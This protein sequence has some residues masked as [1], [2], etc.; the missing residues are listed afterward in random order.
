M[1]RKN[2]M[3]IIDDLLDYISYISDPRETYKVVYPLPT[4]LFTTFCSVLSG[5]QSWQD[6]ADYCGSKKTWFSK[7]VDLSMGIPSPWTFRRLFTLLEPE[8][9]EGLLTKVASLLLEDK[10]SDQIAIDGKS[11]RGSRRSDVSCLKYVSAWCHDNGLV[12]AEKAVAEGSHESKTIPLL[13]ETLNLKGTTVSIDAA[14]CQA[15]IAEKII[16]KKGHYVLSLKKN[17]PK[18]YEAV[19]SYMKENAQDQRAY[20][21]E[22]SFDET[23]NRLVRRRYFACPIAHLKLAV[24]WP[25]LKTAIAVET[26][27]TRSRTSKAT[28]DWRYYVSSH[29]SKN[30][31]LAQYIRNHW[32]IENRLHWVLDVQMNEDNDLKSE[33]KSAKAFATL[34]RIAL[35]IVR[36]KDQT[37]KCSV[38]R[39]MLK[40]AWNED[41]LLN[42]LT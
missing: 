28:A 19:T 41:N 17:Q 2:I 20:L 36:T 25:G 35:N 40:A 10:K 9:L 31:H 12:L 34:R 11:L 24:K 38:R 3:P 22:D 8:V 6:I 4:L 32:G 23:H 33:R 37:P 7:Y 5:C 27:S 14:G 13:L 29:S 30:A 16:Q 1:N 15:S 26:I 21:I 42:L 18:L 39:K